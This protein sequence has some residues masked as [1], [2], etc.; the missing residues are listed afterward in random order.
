MRVFISLLCLSYFSFTIAENDDVEINNKINESKKAIK[1]S[2]SLNDSNEVSTLDG[3]VKAAYNNNNKWD[4]SKSNRRIADKNLEKEN[5]SAWLP[6]LQANVSATSM[7]DRRNSGDAKLT[8]NGTSKMFG[9]ELRQNIFKGMQSSNA[10]ESAR[11][12]CEAA[13]Y[14]LHEAAQKLYLDVLKAYLNVWF[15]REQL[16][17]C[18]KKL[19]NLKQTL[20]A[21]KNN[22]SVGIGTRS[23]VAEAESNHAKAEYEKVAAE[24][25][26]FSYE[27]EFF[28]LTGVKIAKKLILPDVPNF[29]DLSYENLIKEATTNNS[30][31]LASRANEKATSK[32][33][34]KAY[35]ALLPRCDLSLAANRDISK[36]DSRNRCEASIRVTIPIYSNSDGS[37]NAYTNID[38]AQEELLK[39]SLSVKDLL[40]DIQKECV[41]NLNH[42]KS[43]SAM[44]ESSRFAVKSAEIAAESSREESSLGVKSNTD[45]L[46]KENQLLEARIAYA[47][48]VRN[49]IFSAYTLLY[50][51]GRLLLS[52][53][54]LAKAVL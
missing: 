24:T 6:D 26:V 10:I 5:I 3:A 44:I 28:S 4:I 23:E 33:L 47:D 30:R 52:K 43:A 21:A 37:G 11:S 27:S 40:A 12:S 19:H 18:A 51:T 1:K 53:S 46:V 8:T 38:I 29:E 48:S 25:Q 50:L 9:V 49:R 32:S 36:D 20:D 34:D 35:G 7:K 2:S 17:A 22:L 45:V 15:A 41:I 31:I 16:D 39:A 54:N 42:F 13:R 14:S